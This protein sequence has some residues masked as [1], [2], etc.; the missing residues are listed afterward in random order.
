M[1]RTVAGGGAVQHWIEALE[2]SADVAL[3]G[4]DGTPIMMRTGDLSYLGG[5][6][7]TVLWDRIINEATSRAG[8]ETVILPEGLRRRD[9]AT[10]RFYF[11][12]GPDACS[13][14]G[15][16]IPAAGVYWHPL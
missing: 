3:R 6:P 12:Y 8:I 9:T 11:N 5:W 14:D 2:G 15:V 7:D 16:S 1:V 4:D 13:F 10:H